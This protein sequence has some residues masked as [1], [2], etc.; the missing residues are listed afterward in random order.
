MQ[1]KAMNYDVEL[2]KKAI[3]DLE[4]IC[5]YITNELK[6]PQAAK[7]TYKRILEMAESLRR[8]PQRGDSLFDYF[9]SHYRFIWAN[10]YRIVYRV[11]GTNVFI[12]RILYKRRNL[13]DAI[14][15][16]DC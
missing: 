11:Q 3:I 4:Q 2:T 1:K 5:E 12:I 10:N 15:D 9:D 8:F 16:E 6:N 13:D 7:R 14:I